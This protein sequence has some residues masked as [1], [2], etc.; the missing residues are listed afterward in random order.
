MERDEMLRLRREG[1]LWLR[2]LRERAGLSQRELATA[3]GA[4][5]YS[6]ISQLESGKGRVPVSQVELWAKALRVKRSDFA[7]GL[8]RYYD[9]I[10]H[11]MLFGDEAEQAE[12]DRQ[13][14]EARPALAVVHEEAGASAAKAPADRDQRPAAPDADEELRARIDRLEAILMMRGARP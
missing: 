8:L 7:R 14:Q 11:A 3:I 9:P 12:A 6:F 5:Y 4:D 2:G 1:G 13:E 10:T